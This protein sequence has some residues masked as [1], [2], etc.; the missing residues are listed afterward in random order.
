MMIKRGNIVEIGSGKIAVYLDESEA[1]DMAHHYGL[2]DGFSKDLLKA[3]EIAYPK[4]ED[5]E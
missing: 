1:I 2:D 5:D 4:Q 3:V